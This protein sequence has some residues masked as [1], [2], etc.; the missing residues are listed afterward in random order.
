MRTRRVTLILTALAALLFG[1]AA[2]RGKDLFDDVKWSSLQTAQPV[3]DSSSNA[4]FVVSDGATTVIAKFS[5]DVPLTISFADQMLKG[6]NIPV[7]ESVSL[8]VTDSRA[9]AG[10]KAIL[11]KVQDAEKKTQAE[12]ATTLS[13]FEV[14]KSPGKVF[15]VQGVLQAFDLQDTRADPELDTIKKAV[16][17]RKFTSLTQPQR[18]RLNNQLAAVRDLVRCLSDAEQVKLLGRLYA[19]DAFLGNGDRLQKDGLGANWRNLMLGSVGNNTAVGFVAIDNHAFAPSLEELAWQDNYK[20]A[21]KALKGQTPGKKKEITATVA[22]RRDWVERLVHGQRVKAKYTGI[23]DENL[24]WCCDLALVFQP[25]AQSEAIVDDLRPQL[26]RLLFTDMVNLVEPVTLSNKS[27]TLGTEFPTIDPG[28]MTKRPKPKEDSATWAF[29]VASVSD[30][31][32]LSYYA[33][34]IDWAQV[35]A[36][37]TEGMKAELSSLTFMHPRSAADQKNPSFDLNEFKRSGLMTLRN[38]VIARSDRFPDTVAEDALFVRLAY[39]ALRQTNPAGIDDAAAQLK[40]LKAFEADADKNVDYN[41]VYLASPK[42]AP[43]QR[44][45]R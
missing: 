28:K 45:P 4:V 37:I 14:V 11:K 31:G 29:T 26:H 39:L 18:T 8:P 25:G 7:P 5:S 1:S 27:P 15:T 22:G 21:A 40:V 44:K 12:K 20:A 30:Q 3:G 9:E 36:N 23:S 19:I 33:Y 41:L 43:L 32:Q 38:Q 10:K 24:V 42:D 2:A 17:G 13:L 35:V 16:G 6:R 34:K